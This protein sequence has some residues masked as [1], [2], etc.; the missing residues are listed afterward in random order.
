[1]GGIFEKFLSSS[2]PHLAIICKSFLRACIFCYYSFCYFFIDENLIGF[3][4][5]AL[6]EKLLNE[7]DITNQQFNRFLTVARA[8]HIRTYEYALDNIPRNDDLLINARVLNFETRR[9]ASTSI[10]Q[11]LYFI[12]QYVMY[13]LEGGAKYLLRK[14]LRLYS[15]ISNCVVIITV[16]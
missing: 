15:Q 4:I 13:F 11:L 8:F 1:M 14:L 2:K 6:L 9:S 7:G 12:K 16:F 3:A 5:K 10:D